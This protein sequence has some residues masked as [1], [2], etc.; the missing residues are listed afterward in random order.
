MGWGYG[1]LGGGGVSASHC[2]SEKEGGDV[3]TKMC[4]G[5]EI[6]HTASTSLN[7]AHLHCF[8]AGGDR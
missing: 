5:V 1:V 6:F 2:L 7:I 4:R 8:K 3:E